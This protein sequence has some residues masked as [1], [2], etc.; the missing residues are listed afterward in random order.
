[1]TAHLGVNAENFVSQIRDGLFIHRGILSG[2]VINRANYA[3]IAV[4]QK[5]TECGD[6]QRDGSTAL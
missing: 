6:G 4:R 5:P 3:G 1:M 2:I